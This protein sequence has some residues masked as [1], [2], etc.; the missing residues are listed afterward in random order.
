MTTIRIGQL[1][2]MIGI[3]NFEKSGNSAATLTDTTLHK[4]YVIIKDAATKYEGAPSSESHSAFIE[5]RCEVAEAATAVR[6]FCVAYGIM[7][8]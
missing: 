3:A 7:C 1:S 8:L 2:A 6:K 4:G 5:V